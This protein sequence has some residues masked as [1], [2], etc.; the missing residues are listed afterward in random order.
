MRRMASSGIVVAVL[1]ASLCLLP[2]K[3]SYAATTEIEI[4]IGYEE[5]FQVRPFDA[6][7]S[8]SG[9]VKSG[10]VAVLGADLD[11]AY[12]RIMASNLVFDGGGHTITNVAFGVYVYAATRVTVQNVKVQCTQVPQSHGI[13]SYGIY[14]HIGTGHVVKGNELTSC[15]EG[16]SV[17]GSDCTVAGNTLK[18][19]SVGIYVGFVQGSKVSGNNI[20]N[21]RK[22]IEVYGSYSTIFDNQIG[23]SS[24]HGISLMGGATGNKIYHNDFINNTRQGYTDYKH[25]NTWDDGYPN[26]GNHWSDYAGT[27]TH[28]G[29][30][31]DLD[32][33]DGIGDQPYII[34]SANKD[35]Y[36]LMNR[37]GDIVIRED[38]SI[39]PVGAPIDRDGETYKITDNIQSGV[40]VYRSNSIIDG[41]GHMIHEVDG[42]GISVQADNVTIK[43][44]KVT[45]CHNGI[46]LVGGS[47][48]TVVDNTLEENSQTGILVDHSDG[49]NLLNNTADHCEQGIV[50]RASSGTVLSGN[51]ARYNAKAGLRLDQC[52]GSV[53]TDNV[54]ADNS[55]DGIIVSDS[56]DLKLIRNSV[57][58]N[59]ARGIALLG[60]SGNTIIGTDGEGNGLAIVVNESHHNTVVDNKLVR[61]SNGIEVM[62][63]NDCTVS[64]NTAEDNV[65]GGIVL[66]GSSKTLVRGNQLRRNTGSGILLGGG[67]YNEV[68]GNTLVE[69]EIG[70]GFSSKNLIS[71]NDISGKYSGITIQEC[72][73]NAIV[74]NKLKESRGMFIADCD[75]N[76]ISRN[77]VL[78][79][80]SAEVISMTGCHDNVLQQNEILQ[81]MHGEETGLSLLDCSGNTITGNTIWDVSKGIS[82][83]SCEG[84]RIYK[85]NFMARDLDGSTYACKSNKWDNGYP[86][87]G[88]H[89][90]QY[91]GTDLKSGPNQDREGRDGLGDTSRYLHQSPESWGLWDGDPSSLKL[92][93]NNF[94]RYPATAPIQNYDGGTLR[95]E[96]YSV[97]LGTSS[98]VSDFS[99]NSQSNT[100]SFTVSGESGTQG[101]CRLSIPKTLMWCDSPE[102]WAVKMEG[103]DLERTVTEDE[104]ST[105]IYFQYQHSTHHV[106]VISTHSL[107]TWAAGTLAVFYDPRYPTVWISQAAAR[108]YR[109]YLVGQGFASLDADQLELFME[110]SG[111]GTLVVM[112]QDAI[113]DTI[114]REISSDST[115]RTYLDRGGTVVWMKDVPFYYQGHADGTR[116]EWGTK[117]METILGV[118]MGTWDPRDNVT[119]TAYGR[120]KGLTQTWKSLRPVDPAAS[121][122]TEVCASSSGGAASWFK[123]FCASLPESGFIRLWDSTDDFTSIGYLADLLA[124]ASPRREVPLALGWPVLLTGA[125][126]AARTARKG[127]R[128]QVQHRSGRNRSLICRPA[129]R[130]RA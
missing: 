65:G 71:G 110:E 102:E 122:I 1:M 49:N 2:F 99:I 48:H 62:N 93:A 19:N 120:T 79:P 44:L 33:S 22:G 60:S 61:N 86:S 129:P 92:D 7:I 46:G 81:G 121:G 126:L 105:S 87:G 83:H 103:Q 100:V 54:A 68:S 114:A 128:S 35:R 108:A 12:V 6:P 38:G 90:S 55:Y 23:N 96:S 124:V 41:N 72:D 111:P 40:R 84:N 53:L 8:V 5:K 56:W 20:S 30:K 66:E 28:R 9:D 3:G 34:D 11:G 123:N 52:S 64:G 77:S 73:D 106:D 31:Q 75:R 127:R 25:P 63:S 26:G 27:D 80:Y 89:W 43:D 85:N 57:T 130:M 91:S 97:D 116:T 104:N 16:I 101:Y 76:L 95:G 115:I 21:S 32:G 10:G 70:M 98:K 59:P 4:T 119:I 109:D 117:G 18:D 58:A 82:L 125:W 15:G 37:P 24:G 88:N 69:S 94:D 29:Q 45:R 51:T 14:L 42:T 13:Q 118:Y 112:A 17:H 50:V 74:Q 67:S 107:H 36:P 47:R 39:T 78:Q 113:P